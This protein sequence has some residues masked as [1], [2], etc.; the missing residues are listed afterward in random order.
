MYKLKTIFFPHQKKRIIKINVFFD[1]L[2]DASDKSKNDYFWFKK[3]NPI[4]RPGQCYRTS[5]G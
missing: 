4:L 5:I 2:T 1:E 3:S